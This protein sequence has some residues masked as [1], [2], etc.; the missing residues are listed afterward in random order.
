M[1]EPR[2]VDKEMSISHREFLRILPGAL[3]GRDCR[4]DG[5]RVVVG[6]G[7][8]RVEITLGA[9]GER[10]IAL[11]RLPVTPVRIVFFGHTTDETEAFLARFER[12]FQR[13]GG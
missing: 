9:E 1:A 10:R 4:R 6:E 2:V 8:R 7:A 3:D 13:G 5:A 11:L 12:A